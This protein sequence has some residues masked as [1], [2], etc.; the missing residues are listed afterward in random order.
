M[1]HFDH[2]ILSL[3][4]LCPQRMKRR[5]IDHLVPLQEQNLPA[6]FGLALHEGFAQWYKTGDAILCDKAFVEAF[7]PFAN[8]IDTRGLISL[9]RGLE[10]LY[11]YRLH[12][13]IANEPF[14]SLGEEMFEIGFLVEIEG[15]PYCYFGR[16]DGAVNAE[17]IFNGLAVLEHK[18]T[19][20]YGYLIPQPN[21]QIDGYLYALQQMLSEPV[22]GCILN[23]INY[24]AK[25][26][27]KSKN[28]FTRQLTCR[29]KEHIEDWKKDTVI[30]MEK[31]NEDIK[32]KHFPKNTNSCRAFNRNCPYIDLCRNTDEDVIQD[33]IKTYFKESIWSPYPEAREE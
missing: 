31:V 29:T 25:D 28:T 10:I 24:Q 1:L 3:Y 14:K 30:W 33:M 23:I 4:R 6:S 13:P 15:T 8:I 7:M 20:S 5:M 26:L 22:L 18:T 11:L 21:H 19:S 17:M 27:A 9:S 32:R 12:Y 2:T 16:M